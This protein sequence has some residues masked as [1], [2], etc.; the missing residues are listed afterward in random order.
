MKAL[1]DDLHSGGFK[2][3]LYATAGFK[4]VYGYE[5]RWAK[6]LF[7]EWGADEANID[8]VR[9]TDR[10]TDR[11]IDRALEIAL[12]GSSRVPVAITSFRHW[13][14]FDWV[15]A[16]PPVRLPALPMQMCNVPACE[17]APGDLNQSGINTYHHQIVP[18][19]QQQTVERWAAAIAK[20]NKTRDVLF[21]NCDIGCSPSEGVASTQPRPWYVL[22]LVRRCSLQDPACCGIAKTS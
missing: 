14:F 5:E 3:G 13:I 11:Q 15:P 20:V 16:C 12:R 18:Y 17:N 6:V 2:L 4:A 19:Y 1:A 22:D 10:Q 9:A 8:H 7:E 21:H